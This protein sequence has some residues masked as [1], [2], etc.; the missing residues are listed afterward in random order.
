M[1]SPESGARP[2]FSCQA[3]TAKR[4]YLP[5]ATKRRGASPRRKD[6]WRG[7]A[8]D[9]RPSSGRST[10]ARAVLQSCEEIAYP[11]PERAGTT[12]NAT[13]PGAATTAARAPRYCPTR[14]AAMGNSR[15]L[16]RSL[17]RLAIAPFSRSPEISGRFAMRSSACS[18]GRR[19]SAER[20][21]TTDGVARDPRARSAPKSASAVSR[22]RPSRA[23]ALHPL[24][25]R[26]RSRARS[27]RR[28]SHRARP[29]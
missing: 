18:A 4:G 8:T 27:P 26:A 9:P 24:L 21:S 1:P 20:K 25:D 14:S 10:A 13:L 22:V 2:Q 12:R 23:A 28:G 7:F 3:G 16:R 11:D 5:G 29:L 17:V 15:T 19:W 6:F